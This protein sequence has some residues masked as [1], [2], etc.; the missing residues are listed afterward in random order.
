MVN[1]LKSEDN[2][3]TSNTF[4]PIR[5]HVLG[6]LQSLVVTA[7]YDPKLAAM[8]IVDIELTVDRTSLT[9]FFSMMIVMFMWL[10]SLSMLALS[11]D[12]AW[13]HR[14]VPPPCTFTLCNF[15][16]SHIKISVSRRV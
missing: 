2:S 15:V 13:N 4:I 9:K 7:A 8:G 12:I 16:V 11:V 6:G 5:F 14:D 10:V 3:A 1:Y